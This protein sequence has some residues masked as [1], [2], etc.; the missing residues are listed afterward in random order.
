[1]RVISILFQKEHQKTQTFNRR[2]I[3]T[4]RWTI[5]FT[6]YSGD[7]CTICQNHIISKYFYKTLKNYLKKKRF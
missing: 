1:M 5:I 3:K 4:E 2:S 7:N 6:F